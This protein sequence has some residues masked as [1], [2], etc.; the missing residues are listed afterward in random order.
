MTKE[1]KIVK[2]KE[3][4]AKIS[5]DFGKGSIMSLSEKL[6]NDIKVVNT[7][8]LG[9]D[10]I[11]GIG[12]LPRGRIVEIYGTESSGKTTL[13]I[14]T[15]AEAQKNGGLCAFIDAE[16]A[17]SIEY[18]RS[19]GVNTDELDFSQPDCGEQGLEIAERLAASGSYDVIVVDSVAALVPLAEIQGEMGESKM[20]LHA[21]LMSQACRK[22]VG[23]VS[24]TE[25]LLIF[26]NQLRDK[27]GVMYGSPETTTG[28]NALKFYASVRLDVR[29]STT[30]DNSVMDGD[31][32]IGNQTT[33]KVI[34]SKVA[35]PFG[36]CEFDIMYGKGIDKVGELLNIA[37]E[38]G[39]IEKSGSWFT[40]KNDLRIQGKDSFR[41][42]LEDN[43]D[44]TL[45][46]EKEI[47]ERFIK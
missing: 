38:L 28:G 23:V 45:A 44:L 47:R 6:D 16:H 40:Y 17:F 33:V 4:K 34:K 37:I 31:T 8:S 9:L 7:G 39:I 21:R 35:P 3:V 14:H 1:E 41:Q 5:K 13:A 22:L 24:K 36:K 10:V 12:G 20:G 30:K 25:T 46:I 11:L 2:Q 43:S 27:I 29:R 42:L 26:I 19:L 18:A 15:I 32:K